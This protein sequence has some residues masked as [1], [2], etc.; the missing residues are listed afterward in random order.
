MYS[1]TGYWAQINKLDYFFGFNSLL[2]YHKLCSFCNKK[3][4]FNKSGV[5][6][7]GGMEIIEKYPDWYNRSAYINQSYD[8][9]YLLTIW[10]RQRD[11]LIRILTSNLLIIIKRVFWPS[12]NIATHYTLEL[13]RPS[14]WSFICHYNIK[15]KCC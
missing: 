2:F 14:E 5:Q 9:I 3:K 15:V 8:P 13:N 10:K 11:I 1:G 12:T 4:S 6:I 7:F